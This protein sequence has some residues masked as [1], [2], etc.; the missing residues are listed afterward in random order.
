MTPPICDGCNGLAVPSEYSSVTV[1]WITSPARTM[2]GPVTSAV[3]S[4]PYS[5]PHAVRLMNNSATTRNRPGATHVPILARRTG[6]LAALDFTLSQ[7]KKRVHQ[8]AKAR[9]D[10]PRRSPP[11][12]VGSVLLWR[13]SARLDRY[14]APFALRSVY[15]ILVPQPVCVQGINLPCVFPAPC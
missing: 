3:T 15:K 10:I 5:Q 1:S 7:R 9:L 8:T 14:T 13:A 11:L 12:L 4:R 2:A 6:W